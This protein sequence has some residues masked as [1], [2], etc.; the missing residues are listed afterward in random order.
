[1]KKFFA[2]FLCIFILTFNTISVKAMDIGVAIEVGQEVFYAGW[3]Q[4]LA[5]INGVVIPT[6]QY[7]GAA[8]KAA[9]MAAFYD[10]WLGT[11]SGLTQYWGGDIADAETG[12]ISINYPLDYGMSGRYANNFLSEYANLTQDVNNGFAV[13]LTGNVLSAWNRY[14]NLWIQ[15][16]LNAFNGENDV[17]VPNPDSEYLSI[18]NRINKPYLNG[19]GFFW[20][21]TNSFP[22]LYHEQYNINVLSSDFSYFT[23]NNVDYIVP[24][25]NTTNYMYYTPIADIYITSNGSTYSFNEQLTQTATISLPPIYGSDQAYSGYFR[26]V[27][28]KFTAGTNY[29]TPGHTD[30]FTFSYSGTL[31]Q[32]LNYLLDHARNINIYVDGVLWSYVGGDFVEKITA[33]DVIRNESGQII[34]NDVYVPEQDL[35]IDLI[36]WQN[37][38]DD[39]ILTGEDITFDDLIDAGVITDSEGNLIDQ[40]DLDNYFKKKSISSVIDDS[41]D[42]TEAIALVPDL[43]VPPTDPESDPFNW[44]F[45]EFIPDIPDVDFTPKQTG[46]SVLARIINVTNNSLPEEL[47]AMF[48]GISI[49]LLILGIIKIAHK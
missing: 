46:L 27:N 40:E 3:D 44:N 18:L 43:P 45:P 30:T 13:P 6:S 4:V 32:C 49:T 34:G 29:N 31:N 12:A 7:A 42:E 5:L 1:M 35:M 10:D 39:K 36:N 19:Y 16:Y 9:A 48:W 47:I 23:T 25:A 24:S 11:L 2:I 38:V 22:L 41:L 21:N 17:P 8:D 28:N 14:N 33:P 26:I 20:Q 37:L 15:R